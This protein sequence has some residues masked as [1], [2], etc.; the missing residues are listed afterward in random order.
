AD[1]YVPIRP[2]TDVFL[3]LGMVNV[4]FEAGLT[5]PGRL[6]EHVAGLDELRTLTGPFTPEHVAPRCGVDAGTIRALAH[7][8]AGAGRA[9]VYG[10]IGTTTVAYGTVTSWLVDVL[11]ILTGN[12]DRAGGAMFPLPAH[13]RRG[14]GTGPGFTVGR[15]HSRVRGLPEILGE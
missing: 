6:G 1:R 3:L 9:A 10:R 13:S 2:G 14:T 15:W 4:L 5:K 8:L 11:N 12:L 7:D